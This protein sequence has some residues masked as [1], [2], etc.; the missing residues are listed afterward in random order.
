MTVLVSSHDLKID[1][2]IPHHLL[3]HFF[4]L[5]VLC[6]DDP[7]QKDHILIVQSVHQFCLDPYPRQSV[8]RVD[9]ITTPVPHPGRLTASP[10]TSVVREQSDQV[11]PEHQS[12]GGLQSLGLD[13]QVWGL[14]FSL[15][16][17]VT[18]SA[19]WCNRE[20]F[21]REGPYLQIFVPVRS[22][23]SIENVQTDRCGSVK[24]AR[25]L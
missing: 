12:N 22:C 20:N 10:I 7:F 18:P 4:L 8:D 25:C 23:Q 2:S 1:R 11:P 3:L 21:F 6:R 24:V 14:V 17:W 16:L 5:D 9:S 15:P 19:H 13:R